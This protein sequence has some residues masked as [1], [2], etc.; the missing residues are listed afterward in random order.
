[1]SIYTGKPNTYTGTLV[2]SG[3]K[4]FKVSAHTFKEAVKKLYS[5]GDKVS[6][7][8]YDEMTITKVVKS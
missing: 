8:V 1:M 3:R 7:R 6:G 2:F 4:T 5:Q